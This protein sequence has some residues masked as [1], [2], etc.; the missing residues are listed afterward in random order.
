MANIPIQQARQLFTQQFLGA[1]RETLPPTNFFRSFLTDK[2]VPAKLVSTEVMRGTRKIA[3][4]ITRG[5]EGNKNKFG[6]S[7]SK[8]FLPPYYAE[9]FNN[10][11]LML[12]DRLF[13]DV[14]GDIQPEV[15]KN[16]AAEV[17]Q[18]YSE[19]KNK[20]DRAYEKQA[21][22]VFQSGV[23][24]TIA[25]DAIDYKAKAS[26]IATLDTKWDATTP[27]ILESLA[28]AM[29]QL[30][31]DGAASVEFNVVMG[32]AALMT[33]MNSDVYQKKFGLFQQTIAQYNLPRANKT[34]GA[35]LINRIPVGPYI[36]NVWSYNDTYLNDAGTAV[37]FL[38]PKKVVIIAESFQG[39]MSFAQVPRVI[40]DNGILQNTGFAQTLDNGAYVLNNFIKPEVSSHVF[41]IKSAGLVV[42]LTIDH[43][44]CLTVLA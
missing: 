35:V 31:I 41:E 25:N 11:E 2:V 16:V 29:D 13:G 22:D 5:N 43:F 28:S 30:K 18:N 19:L 38:D 26:H 36:V 33:F 8:T 23:V 10:T 44:S 15:L 40:T 24:T 20:I 27:K 21:A 39:F 4:D 42:P 14:N 3:A 1:W 9:N 34:T 17:M 32:S 37:P 6:L 12:Y 7:T